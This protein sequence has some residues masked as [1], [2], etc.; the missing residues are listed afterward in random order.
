MLS[1]FSIYFSYKD[2]TEEE[3][4]A[5]LFDINNKVDTY[6]QKYHFIYYNTKITENQQIL[7][8]KS[9]KLYQY[10]LY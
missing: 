10:F 3:I 5:E 1:G 6:S 9:C 7:Y 4:Y 2:K 8:G